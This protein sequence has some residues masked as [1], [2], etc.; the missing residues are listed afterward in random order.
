MLVSLPSRIWLHHLRGSLAHGKKIF[1]L[2][3]FPLPKSNQQLLSAGLPS[4]GT[5]G[6]EHI[7][8]L[9]LSVLKENQSR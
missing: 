4:A 5:H 7:G 9:A 3:N 6:R 8:D 2:P 1:T